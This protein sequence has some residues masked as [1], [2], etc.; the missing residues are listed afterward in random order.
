MQIPADKW[1][2][3]IFQR[4]SRRQFEE[5]S[6][7]E[8]IIDRL[9]VVARQLNDDVP[10][11]RAV[12]VTENPSAVF[13]GAVG[14]YG[15]IKGAPA[16][17]AFVGNMEDSSVQE[18]VG[19]LGE[20]FVLEAT[21]LGLATCWIGAFFRPNLVRSQINIDSDEQVLAVSP[22]GF[23]KEHYT[24]EEK[25]M[26]GIVM[27]R[28]RK[29]LEELYLNK[30]TEPLSPWV[31]SALEAAR[32]APS[33]VNRQPWRFSVENE[34]IKISVDNSRD[35]YHISKR[36]D[37]GIAMA[38]IEIAANHEGVVGQWEHLSSPDVARFRKSN[39]VK[40]G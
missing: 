11:A 28:K 26:S 1:Y 13:K 8:E 32:I 23:A 10:G 12:L 16:Y 15:K 37:C 39:E 7:P 35:S 20:I 27:S 31:Q 21:S 17:V 38:H 34:A 18:K 25:L 40:V 33:A 2:S 4:L 36:L 14:A 3:A 19:R 22:I 6:L 29:N 30:P 24:L 5:R 9:S